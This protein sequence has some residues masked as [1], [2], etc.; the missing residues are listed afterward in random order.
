MMDNVQNKSSSLQHTIVRPLY[1][2]L[3]LCKTF[4]IYISTDSRYL[5][6]VIWILNEEFN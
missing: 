2:H 3:F 6:A 4:N 5:P 1:L